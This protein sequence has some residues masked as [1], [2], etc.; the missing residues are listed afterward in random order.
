MIRTLIIR[1]IQ[2]KIYSAQFMVITLLCVVL[3]P[4]G[5]YISMKDFE[6][7]HIEY[8]YN[9]Q[10][11]Y[12]K[13]Q[14]KIH[15]SFRAEGYRPPSVLNIFSNGLND[16]LPYKT[17]TDRHKGYTI[18]TKM[19]QSNPIS[20][21]FGK[22]DF[23]LMVTSFLSI[24]SIIFTFS[25]VSSEKE[26]GTIRLIFSNS[27]QRW[28]FV[29]AKI[30]GN[31]ILFCIPFFLS[32][33]MGLLILNTSPYIS[34]FDTGFWAPFLFISFVT[35]LLILLLLCLGFLIST[36]THNS[37][38][39][40][41]TL[42][43]IWVF[44]AFII[45]KVSPMIA[46]IVYPVDSAEVFDSKRKA[47]INDMEQEYNKQMKNLFEQKLIARNIDPATLND[48]V[49]GETKEARKE[50]DLEKASLN[51]E[52]N[53]RLQFELSKLDGAYY[54]QQ[55][56]QY[57]ISRN[58]ARVSPIS[59]YISLMSEVCHTGFCEIDNFRKQAAM[60]QTQVEENVYI[61][62]THERYAAGPRTTE[63]Y[64]LKEGLDWRTFQQSIP[65]PEFHY[66]QLTLSSIIQYVR[67]DFMLVIF[68]CVVFF[69]TGFVSFLR[70]DVR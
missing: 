43:F 24:L 36:I 18:E 37:L 66:K 65:V 55:Q 61:H 59:S 38:T 54:H 49:S 1:E 7:K 22:I 47:F 44:C 53:E 28:K 63:G 67:I 69:V 10:D 15:P 9:M 3:I 17:V 51:E 68:F 35:L 62:W 58:I 27:V 19:Q 40:I 2:D 8:V 11:Y 29:V 34:I 57:S 56:I 12:Q 21:L 48:L 20:I 41:V 70:Y 14:T 32:I 45:P 30:S 6:K 46:Q 16:Y 52:Y 26:N 50:Y 60:L 5:L 31:Y 64:K 13:S 39:S 4:L 33:I 25:C 23:T 42:L